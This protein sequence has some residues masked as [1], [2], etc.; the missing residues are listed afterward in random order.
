MEKNQLGMQTCYRPHEAIITRN[1]VSPLDAGIC[2]LRD[3]YEREA[4]TTNVLLDAG[5][6]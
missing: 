3:H 1:D 4:D 5:T 6:G 2:R